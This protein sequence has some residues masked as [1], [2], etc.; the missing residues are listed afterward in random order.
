[1][2][3]DEEH[4]AFFRRL[5]QHAY[6]R[7]VHLNCCPVPVL[8][9]QQE[10]FRKPCSLPFEVSGIHAD[11]RIHTCCSDQ[12]EFGYYS[13]GYENIRH[14]WQSSNFIALR[15][16]VNSSK[17]LPVGQHREVVCSDTRR[18]RPLFSSGW[19]RL[20][21]ETLSFLRLIQER[22]FNLLLQKMRERE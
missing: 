8:L 14:R 16:T 13:A 18:S 7:G 10:S 9:T 1:M 21:R 5:K 22:R 6:E 11:G 2:Y 12:F 3:F 17:P 15:Q 4:N 20:C 19:Q